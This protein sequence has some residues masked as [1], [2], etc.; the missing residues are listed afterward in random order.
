M[1]K[2]NKKNSIVNAVEPVD[3]ETHTD[4][5]TVVGAVFPMSLTP[6]P[7]GKQRLDDVKKRQ[8]RKLDDAAS[9]NTSDI[10]L[11][12]KIDPIIEHLNMIAKIIAD[13][14]KY[15]KALEERDEDRI[16]TF[17]YVYTKVISYDGRLKKKYDAAAKT[18]LNIGKSFY[19]YDEKHRDFISDARYD[20]L[21]AT[22]LTGDNVEPSGII[23]KGKKNM[24]KIKVTYPTLHNNMDKSY[25]VRIADPIPDGVKEKDCVEKFLLRAYKALGITSEVELE[26]ELSPKIDGV[27]INGT[28]VGDSIRNPQTRGD[29]S[30]SVS[31]IG[32]DNLQ[33]TKFHND[34]TFGI[35]YEAFV[36]EDDRKKASAYLGMAEPYVSCRH[37]AAG[38]ISRLCTKEDNELL[39]YLSLFPIATEGLDGV[40]TETVD[41]I[42]NF[43][44]VPKD[45]IERKIIKGTMTQLL[46][47]ITKQFQQFADKRGKLSYTIDGMIITI[48]DSDEQELIGREGRTNR[49]QIAL[50]FDPASA[51]SHTSGIW[52]DTGRKGYRTIQVELDKPVYLD[53][54]RY[55]HVPVLSANLYKELDLR[56]GSMVRIRRVG[57]VIPSIQVEQ[58]GH[59]KKL[60]LPTSCPS[61]GT[62]MIIK[63]KKLYCPSPEC[64][65]NV[66]GR[67]TDFFE[68]LEMADY[69]ESFAELLYTKFGVTSIGGLFVLVNGNT[70]EASGIN[71]KK[72]AEFPEVLRDTVSDTIDYRVIAALGIPGIGKTKAKQLLQMYKPCDMIS[73]AAGG[74]AKSL[75]FDTQILQLVGPQT[76]TLTTEFMHS[77]MFRDDMKCIK[78]YIKRI[79]KHFD[80]PRVGH[81]G[82]MPSAKIKGLVE[83]IGYEIVDGKSFDMLLVPNKDYTSGKTEVAKKKNLPIFTEEEFLDR[84][85]TATL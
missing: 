70:I 78:P 49:Y 59:G 27:S 39:Q 50:K 30:E 10:I 24:K 32:M 62:P 64:K 4:T 80:L 46:G 83:L 31:V 65:D 7:L 12:F 84:F 76:T 3:V 42:Q 47:K 51:V 74:T 52:L 45:M 60:E 57:D 44:V 43:A 71:S 85:E 19:E 8:L 5:D 53:G 25:A 26:V 67:L 9:D 63:G 22:Y 6:T 58:R 81:S 68:K 11:D 17:V 23:P 48:I 2:K 73:L 35:Q 56:E 54:V 69:G 38:I 33:V 40:Y 66:I 55:D 1:S 37:A 20:A 36:T 41:Y 34:K 18:L 21:L 29:D 72:L 77:D 28:I 16:N 75:L 61:C 14:G 79:T 82:I 15:G 13:S